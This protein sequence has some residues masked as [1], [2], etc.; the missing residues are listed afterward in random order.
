MCGLENKYESL[1]RKWKIMEYLIQK[2]SESYALYQK[3]AIKIGL[4]SCKFVLAENEYLIQ[5]KIVRDT[6]VW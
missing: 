4:F 2:L 1:G 5:T 6:R 3:I